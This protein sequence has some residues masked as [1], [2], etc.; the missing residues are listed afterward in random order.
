MHLTI[1]SY[2]KK[3]IFLSSENLYTIILKVKEKN[4]QYLTGT[5]STC[6]GGFNG[7]LTFP[8]R[9]TLSKK[10]VIIALNLHLM[11]HVR[12]RNLHRFPH[13]WLLCLVSILWQYSSS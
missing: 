10:Y 5:F 3:Y 1:M 2:F 8:M 13:E 4:L 9:T 12:G 11:R 6:L 7:I